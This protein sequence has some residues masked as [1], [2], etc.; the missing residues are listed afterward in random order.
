MEQKAL[1]RYLR[2]V[3]LGIGILGLF[4]CFVVI[5]MYGLS[6]KS[7]Y[8][9]FS[10]RFWPWLIFLWLSAVPCFISLAFLWRVASNIGLDRSFSSE[11][12][13]YLK[14]VSR[15]FA[16]DS[17]FFFLG[18]ATLLLLNMSH[19][20]VML[21][22]LAIVFVGIA[23]SVAAAVL[24]RLALKASDLQTQSDLTV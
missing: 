5:P 23:A 6:L 15:L 17:A 11:N 21:A 4:A 2:L 16:V 18:N 14:Q 22:S 7:M 13:G 24:S 1:V 12:A 20:G 3:I 19:P 8:P 10:N 9:E